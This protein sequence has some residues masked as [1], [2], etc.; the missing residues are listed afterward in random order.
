M[1]GE[2]LKKNYKRHGTVFYN[3]YPSKPQRK[4]G[5]YIIWVGRMEKHKRPGWFLELARSL[6]MYNFVMVGGKGDPCL[7]LEIEK[8]AA[9]IENL[10]YLGHQP[11]E[12][13]EALF[14]QAA[15][16]INTYNIATEGFPN[17]FFQA[18]SRGISI[19]PSMDLDELISKNNIGIVAGLTGGKDM[20]TS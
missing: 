6:P 19:V 10:K 16:F 12:V 20:T 4:N 5:R 17:T 11:F 7:K 8:H 9:K 1:Q 2:L 18:L 3:I 15:I 14:N 13:V